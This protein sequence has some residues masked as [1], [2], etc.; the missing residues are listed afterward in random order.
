MFFSHPTDHPSWLELVPLWIINMAILENDWKCMFFNMMCFFPIVKMSMFFGVSAKICLG[1]I[2]KKVRLWIRKGWS[3]TIGPL[4]PWSTLPADTIFLLPGVRLVTKQQGGALLLHSTICWGVVVEKLEA[5]KVN[6]TQKKSQP[7]HD[8][9]VSKQI[10][11]GDIIVQ[12][13]T[14]KKDNSFLQKM[15]RK[16][17]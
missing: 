11:N 14:K 15:P 12:R 4:D 10:W 5:S 13:C 16:F 17:S 6:S 9:M 3:W 1:K 7:G 2:V 8:R